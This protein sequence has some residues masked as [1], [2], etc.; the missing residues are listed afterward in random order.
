M[1]FQ[2][3]LWAQR[4]FNEQLCTNTGGTFLDYLWNHFLKKNFAPFS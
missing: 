4:H 2:E 3:G 1:T